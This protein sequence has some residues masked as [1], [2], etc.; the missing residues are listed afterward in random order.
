MEGCEYFNAGFGGYPNAEGVVLLDVGLMKG[1]GE[2]SAITNLRRVRFPSEVAKDL[3][4]K[5]KR[6]FT[7]WTYDKEKNLDDADDETKARYGWVEKH[8]DLIA[9]YVTELL[10]K[11]KGFEVQNDDAIRGTIG[12]VVRDAKGEIHSGTSTGGTSYK[13]NGRIGDSPIIGAG[14]FADNEVVLQ[15]MLF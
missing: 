13:R 1:S 3:S 8:E 2:F 14:V 11:K 12:C 15:P 5:Y 4:E 6:L 9:P 10:E 7:I